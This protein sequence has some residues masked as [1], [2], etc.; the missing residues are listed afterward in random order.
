MSKISRT[1][2]KGL[3]HT[4]QAIFGRDL[5]ANGWIEIKHV[6]R[7]LKITGEDLLEIVA[8][9]DKQ[10]FEIA[11]GKIRAT[12]GHSVKVDLALTPEVPPKEL[13][14]GTSADLIAKI[15]LEGLNKASRHAVHLSLE[16][17]TAHK[18]ALRKNKNTV[19][20]AINAERMHA[21]G[22]KFTV[23]ENGVWLV[24]NVPPIYLSIHKRGYEMDDLYK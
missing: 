9:N 18:V 14:H 10:R 8:E 21:D 23:S 1:L 11:N 3:R 7:A 22:F 16:T 15:Y 12:Q 6:L 2:S 19:I 20:F 5:D 24:D 17:E 4:P 13:Y